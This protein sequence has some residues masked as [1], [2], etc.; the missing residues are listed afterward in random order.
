MFIGQKKMRRYKKYKKLFQKLYT[1]SM[2]QKEL[3]QEN[4]LLILCHILHFL[5]N[6]Y[7]I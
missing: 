4:I 7:G 1:K 5:F 6:F 2:F 3:K